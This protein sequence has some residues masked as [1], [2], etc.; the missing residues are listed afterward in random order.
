MI[1]SLDG[2]GVGSLHK[3]DVGQLPGGGVG[4][5]EGSARSIYHAHLEDGGWGGS[6]EGEEIIRGGGIAGGDGEGGV[7]GG[8]ADE[9]A[10][11]VFPV[12]EPVRVVGNGHDDPGARNGIGF[13]LHPSLGPGGALGVL[14]EKLGHV[15]IHEPLD[16]GFPKVG[17]DS[18][19]ASDDGL[20]SVFE[21]TVTVPMDKHPAFTLFRTEHVGVLST[22][23]GDGVPVS[24]VSTNNG[25][26]GHH[27][28]VG[29]A[30]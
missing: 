2:E 30:V 4:P 5:R 27:V 16:V 18:C 26:E 14:V 21:N 12:V 11:N 29:H 25:I 22:I 10:S 28:G 20:A 23:H 13:S 7:R 8:V 17:A 24:I 3:R 1:E 6:S 9:I 15:V 19:S